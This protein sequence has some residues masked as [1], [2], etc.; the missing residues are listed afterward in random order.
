MGA[1]NLVLSRA[2]SDLV[3][4][5]G[6]LIYKNRRRTWFIAKSGTH[7]PCFD[8]RGS[9]VRRRSSYSCSGPGPQRWTRTCPGQTRWSLWTKWR[10]QTKTRRPRKIEK[11][12]TIVTSSLTVAREAAIAESRLAVVELRTVGTSVLRRAVDVVAP[13]IEP[14]IVQSVPVVTLTAIAFKIINR[15]RLKRWWSNTRLARDAAF[16]CK[17]I[18]FKHNL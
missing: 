18:F 5:L 11:R 4:A 13:G 9:E 15:K 10:N 14:K 6:P 12:I 7:V 2:P 1:P 3:T 17:L 8:N 16:R